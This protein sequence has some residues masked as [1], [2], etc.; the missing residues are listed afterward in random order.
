MLNQHPQNRNETVELS[1]FSLSNSEQ[2]FFALLVFGI[3]FFAYLMPTTGWWTM[4]PGDLGDARFNSIVLEHVYQWATGQMPSLWSPGFF[5]PFEGALAFSDN[6]LGSA[7]VYGLARLCGLTRENAFLTWF[8]VGNLLNFVVCTLVLRR[9]GFSLIS[10]V[11]GAF[12]FSFALPALHKENHA[13]LVYRF[14]VPL[15]FASWYRAISLKSSIDLARTSFWVSIQILCSIYLGVFLVYLL[16]AVLAAYCLCQ[17]C[18]WSKIPKTKT[19][20]FS[21]TNMSAKALTSRDLTF[22]VFWYVI[23]FVFIGLAAYL[24]LQYHRVSSDYHFARP[25]EELKTM[26]PRLSSYLLADGSSL[27]GWIGKLLVNVPMRHEQQMFFGIGV[28][29]LLLPGFL[30][31]LFFS[32][33]RF[34]TRQLFEL[35]GLAGLALIFVFLLTISIADHSLYL[36]IAKVPGLGSIRAISRVVLIMLLPAAL[37]VAVSAEALLK[38][39]IPKYLKSFFV[40]FFIFLIS[41]EVIYYNPIHVV[42]QAWLVRQQNLT[43][44][45]SS[46]IPAGDILY[47]S[48]FKDDPWFMTEIDAVI[49]AQDHGLLTLNGYSGNIPPGYTFPDPC[50]KPISRVDGY[51]AHRGADPVRRQGIVDKINVVSGVS[52]AGGTAGK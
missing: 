13:Q 29:I 42:K 28:W 7:A 4:T 31:G 48:Q 11:L 21:R 50:A 40:L 32:A 17:F 39:K 46:P 41:V 27:S 18:L 44:R 12:V 2:Y 34:L 8:V 36:L 3:A 9:L 25:V 26:L 19:S 16:L 38:W 5:F 10:S 43:E 22:K 37:L 24:L 45:I 35:A 33:N 20:V 30:C 6:H 23:A 49:Y 14:A 1:R 47:V 52:C 15:A 51:F